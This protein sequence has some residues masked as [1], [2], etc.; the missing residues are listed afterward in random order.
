VQGFPLYGTG[1]HRIGGTLAPISA[2]R[3]AIIAPGDRVTL[4]YRS[5]FQHYALVLTPAPLL[6]KLEALIGVPVAAR[7]TFTTAVSYDRPEA[8][9][10][11]RLVLFLAKELSAEDPAM[12]PLALAELEQALMVSFLCSNDSNYGASLRGD[13]LRSA[14][15]QVRRAEEYIAAHW[16][17][18]ITIEAL[19]IAANVSAR[20]LFYSF[21]KA[22][23]Y[24]PMEL[25]K[26]IR[27]EH[28]RGMLSRPLPGT[29]VTRIG[30]ACG[31][32]NLGHFANDYHACFGE[33]PSDTLR[34][35]RSWQRRLI[36]ATTAALAH[37]RGPAATGPEHPAPEGRPRAAPRGGS[38]DGDGR[39]LRERVGR[40]RLASSGMTGRIAAGRRTLPAQSSPAAHGDR[41]CRPQA[42]PCQVRRTPQ[43]TARP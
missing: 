6:Q 4:R 17:Q 28:A 20:S 21:K 2:T 15:W 9:A 41:T 32:G 33:R 34:R 27:L 38:T 7:L 10:L 19:A 23:G 35:C 24:S 40:Q 12:P 39:W 14:P 36:S 43:P 5:T 30:Y 1:E 11:R 42:G 8:L 3:S 16:D 29:S 13:P 37:S 26:R 31:F 22:R 18:P 25:V